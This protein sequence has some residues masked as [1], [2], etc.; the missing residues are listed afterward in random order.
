ML[1]ANSFKGFTVK[2]L[3]A[4][5]PLVLP[6]LLVYGGNFAHDLISLPSASTDRSI[7]DFAWDSAEF[8]TCV[9][10]LINS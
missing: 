5:D 10:E 4:T 8:Y 9:K 6:P 7:D 1:S 2:Q 3:S